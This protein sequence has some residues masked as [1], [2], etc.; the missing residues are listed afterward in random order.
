MANAMNIDLRVRGTRQVNDAADAIDRLTKAVRGY[1]QASGGGAVAIN[2]GGGRIGGGGGFGRSGSLGQRSLGANGNLNLAQ[3]QYSAALSSGNVQMIADAQAKLVRAQQAAQRQS[4][5]LN[6]QGTS[7]GQRLQ[8][9]AYSTRF[10]SGASPLVG[11]TLDLFGMGKLAGPIGIVTTALFG[12]A[13][14]AKFSMGRLREIGTLQ[15]I[16]GGSVAQ[17]N[18]SRELAAAAGISAEDFLG[19]ARQAQTGY[20]DDP[21]KGR[22]LRRR[23]YKSPGYGPNRSTNAAESYNKVVRDILMDTNRDRAL[24][25]LQDLGL[26]GL[27]PFIGDRNFTDRLGRSNNGLSRESINAG[28]RFKTGW[29][30]A[31]QSIQD[32]W[33]A[34]GIQMLWD[35]Q[36][37]GPGFFNP[38]NGGSKGSS[39]GNDVQIQTL[40]EIRDGV[41]AIVNGQREFKGAGQGL[42]KAIP[43]AWQ[44]FEDQDTEVRRQ[45]N[46]LGAFGI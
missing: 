13:E 10:G 3:Q 43:S 5:L 15:G 12:L 45:A 25:D 16:G 14:A 8:N 38:S 31:M 36:G 11:R 22:I 29:D 32:Q 34:K 37:L 2:I 33:A 44:W 28:A 1:A 6:P 39:S 20:Y 7:F 40:R 26:D 46:A 17:T 24:R 35:H 30:L 9:W 21:V 19:Q 4:N 42:R 23:G 41:W 27:Q 18:A